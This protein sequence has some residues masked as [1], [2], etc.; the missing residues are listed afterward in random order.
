M[1][2]QN[3]LQSL[4]TAEETTLLLAELFRRA[5]TQYEQ[6]GSW[7]EAAEC[8]VQQGNPKRAGA[9]YTQAGDLRRAARTWLQGGCY[10]E[11]LTAYQQWEQ[12]I[13]GLSARINLLDQF[14]ALLGQSACH[15]LATRRSSSSTNFSPAAGQQT[16]RQARELLANTLESTFPP[17]TA[18]YWEALGDYGGWLGR[19]DLIQEGYEQALAALEESGERTLQVRICTA[20]LAQ[21]RAHADRLLCQELEERLAAWPEDVKR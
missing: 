9:L 10:P 18:S 12:Q 6:I 15:I 14:Q 13:Q 2:E 5:A 20:Y 3:R 7:R 17:A 1:T 8:W 16:Y 21:A 4:I 19:Y 11:A